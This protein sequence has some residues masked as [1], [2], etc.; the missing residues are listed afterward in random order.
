M[1]S[2]NQRSASSHLGGP[3]LM[4]AREGR[5]PDVFESRSSHR[6]FHGVLLIE[7]GDHVV[8]AAA[9]ENR[10]A[11]KVAARFKPPVALRDPLL[12]HPL[13]KN[14]RDVITARGEERREVT[15]PFRPTGL[16]G[17][18]RLANSASRGSSGATHPTLPACDRR[19]SRSCPRGELAS[20]HRQR[21][22][23]SLPRA[24]SRGTEPI[25]SNQLGN[26]WSL[27]E[28]TI[29]TGHV[30][31]GSNPRGTARVATV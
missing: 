24:Q 13:E 29:R 17:A 15:R 12:V 3:H 30:F 27:D 4:P 23:P 11:Q 16:P 5:V 25:R 21:A 31:F 28:N 26:W 7:R 10:S 1:P 9:Q 20:A 14:S 19:A 6:F 8:H 22:G 2:R 18:R